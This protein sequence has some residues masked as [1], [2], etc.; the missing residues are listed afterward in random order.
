M[1]KR[2]YWFAIFVLCALVIATGCA[3]ADGNFSAPAASPAAV[4]RSSV[5]TMTI[6]SIDSGS[7]TLIP[8][9]V[10]K[11]TEKVTLSYIANLVLENLNE[12]EIELTD[13]SQNGKKVI[14]SF[15]SQGR[16]VKNCSATMES[17][18][19]EAFANSLL[20]NV[21]DCEQVIFRCDGEGY[22]S[23]QY[24]FGKNEVYA[25]E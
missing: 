2:V 20:D 9:T 15:S 1:G 8:V 19:L 3:G 10:K 13:V 24:T 25:S 11:G 18:I 17:L 6:Y 23:G 7:M 4:Q 21:E 16:P 22:T 5:K 12:D 14:V